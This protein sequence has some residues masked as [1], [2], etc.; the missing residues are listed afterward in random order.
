L[1]T[2]IERFA[3][4]L[5]H[6][7][8]FPLVLIHKPSSA[9]EGKS[10]P[11]IVSRQPTKKPIMGEQK[12]AEEK[13]AE[14]DAQ[15]EALKLTEEEKKLPSKHAVLS[16][17]TELD[18]EIAR[19]D[20]NMKRCKTLPTHS[21]THPPIF[22]LRITLRGLASLRADLEDAVLA[23]DEER[24]AGQ[25]EGANSSR[26]R[27]DEAGAEGDE[28]KRCGPPACV[29][30]ATTQPGRRS[31]HTCAFL[32][33]VLCWAAKANTVRSWNKYSVRI[34]SARS[35]TGGSSTA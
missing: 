16:R 21:L 5:I 20:S 30:P 11:S 18:D 28:E 26:R 25:R 27:R 13:R 34:A 14:E 2:K 22:N 15:L 12:S 4:A 23:R 8:S 35:A 33:A 7:P 32:F 31:A 24:A 19:A 17:I 3:Y 29:L 9:I 10:R 6:K 1:P